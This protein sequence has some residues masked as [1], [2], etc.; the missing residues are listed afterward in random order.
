V[1]TGYAPERGIVVVAGDADI[2]KLGAALSRSFGPIPARPSGA[3][4]AVPAVDAGAPARTVEMDVERPMI[5]AAWPAPRQY[6][7]GGDLVWLGLSRIEELRGDDIWSRG[8]TLAGL[9][10]GPEAPLMVYGF[11]VRDAELLDRARQHI[12]RIL[13]LE[14]SERPV[15]DNSLVR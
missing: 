3:R 2:D 5:F 13:Q 7:G 10:G 11:V 15:T 1:R 6:T 9:L 4:R 8:D 12:V 14:P